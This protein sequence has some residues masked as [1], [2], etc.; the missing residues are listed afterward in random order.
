MES[1]TSHTYECII[2]KGYYQHY[3][4][5][6]Q[7]YHPCTMYS[8]TLTYC[9][10]IHQHSP[11]SGYVN[12]VHTYLAN[13]PTKT[14]TTQSFSEHISYLIFNIH[15]GHAN[16]LGLQLLLYE[17]FVNFN[18]FRSVMLDRIVDNANG[19]FTIIVQSHG[20]M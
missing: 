17:M 20:I 11:S 7:V 19:S 18:M 9:A 14:K 8:N 16:L 13:N 3:I 10:H 2:K 6:L 1:I 15:K 5:Y 12:F 4:E